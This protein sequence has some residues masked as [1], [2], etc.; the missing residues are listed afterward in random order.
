MPRTVESIE[1]F[2]YTIDMYGMFCGATSFNQPLNDWG[3]SQNHMFE[4]A[5]SFNQ[6]LDTWEVSNVRELRGM[7]ENAKSFN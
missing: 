6:P 7:F 1:Y 4:D 2:E 5:R 3:V